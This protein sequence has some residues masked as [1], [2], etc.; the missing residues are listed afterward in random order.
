MPLI[1]FILLLV[2]ILVTH[3]SLASDIAREIRLKNQIID[4]II[5]GDAV[6]LPTNQS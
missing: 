4:Y 1:N 5:D 6:M 3:T 2:C